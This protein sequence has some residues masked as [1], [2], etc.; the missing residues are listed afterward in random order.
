MIQVALLSFIFILTVVLA[1]ST[2]SSRG[3]FWVLTCHP[4]LHVVKLMDEYK[5]EPSLS[6]L[7]NPEDDGLLFVEMKKKKK[8]NKPVEQDSP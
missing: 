7:N 4:P 8:L 5:R 2:T 3:E 6:S 1:S